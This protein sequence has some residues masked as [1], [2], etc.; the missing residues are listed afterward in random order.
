MM[1]TGKTPEIGPLI[2]QK[3]RFQSHLRIAAG[4]WLHVGRPY[5]FNYL[6]SIS[7]KL[8]TNIIDQIWSFTTNR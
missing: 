8:N 4:P 5:F 3:P 6:R 2:Y 7:L 1:R